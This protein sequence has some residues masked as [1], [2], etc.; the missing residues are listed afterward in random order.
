MAARKTLLFCSLTLLL[1]VFLGPLPSPGADSEPAGGLGAGDV[2]QAEKGESPGPKYD[3]CAR[4]IAGLSTPGSS[5]A[6]YE[7]KPAWVK[8]AA[9][10]NQSWEKFDQRQLAPMREWASRELGSAGTSTV[11]YPF[12]GPDFINIYTLFPR[13]HTYLLVALE[14]V[15][16]LPDFAALDLQDFFASLQRSLSVYLSIDYFATA[17]MATQIGQTQL[18]GVLPLLLFFLA[19]EHARVLDVRYWLMKPD[20][21]IEEQ[22]ATGERNPGPGVPGLRIVFAG[23][24]AAEK[25]TL[26]YFQLNLQNNSFGRNPQFASFL[27]G[28]GPLTAF[29]KSAS[30]LLFSRYSAD[31]RQFIL[32]RSRY[33]LQDDSG[34]PLKD[35]DPAVWNLRFYGTYTAPFRLF[36]NRYQP[37]LAAAYKSG[38]DVYP[39]PFGIGYRYRVGTSN[40]LFAARKT[41]D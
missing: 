16:A 24:G 5:L 4:F 21:A 20:G 39:L 41:G 22:P 13:A 36:K 31:I 25:Q 7:K 18:K 11:F 10:M 23:A 26:Y 27:K 35:F 1:L 9:S 8:F 12:S 19:R 40:L 6:D 32:N 14:P 15:G 38:K 28:F 34:I 30:Y 37:D 3:D 29:T 17:R 2:P 33:V